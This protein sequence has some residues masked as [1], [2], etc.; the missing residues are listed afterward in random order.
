MERTTSFSV[1]SFHGTASI[2][3]IDHTLRSAAPSKT[4]K[5]IV[6]FPS[7]S[8]MTGGRAADHPPLR[9]RNGTNQFIGV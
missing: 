5:C 1:R 6:N 9:V 3:G 4:R 8:L 7:A 2:G